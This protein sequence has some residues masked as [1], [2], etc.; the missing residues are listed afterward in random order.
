MTENWRP[1]ASL[2]MLELRARVLAAVRRF[3]SQRGVLEVETPLLCAGALAHPRTVIMSSARC[4]GRTDSSLLYL[5]TSPEAAMK[6]L[7]AHG[8]GPIYQ[9]CKAFRGCEEDA[10]HNPEFSIVEWY[11][12]GFN[13][14]Q[15]HDE[16]DALL[17]C[18]A[19]LPIGETFSVRELFVD[20][21]S[22]DPIADDRAALEQCASSR[23]LIP[24]QGMNFGALERDDLLELLMKGA[25]EPT[26]GWQAPAFVYGFPA[27][28]ACLARVN[29]DG[30]ADRFEVFVKG[31]EL[32][33]CYHE[34][35]DFPEHVARLDVDQRKRL[36]SGLDLTPVDQRFLDALKHGLPDC[37]GVA[38]GLDRLLMLM[39]G[40]ASLA[41]V[42]AFPVTIA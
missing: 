31:I 1:S 20:R 35:V 40:R 17:Q 21:L 5:Q 7:L 32:A 4:P 11:R 23:G 38:I 10:L 19:G 12:P 15:M 33:N 3:F 22:V 16:V 41:D 29:E 39:A 14:I 2:E 25:I 28:Q 18:V 27:P 6:R 13:H 42:I 8:S 34:L 30:T 37:A 24:P 26:L 9:I 36:N